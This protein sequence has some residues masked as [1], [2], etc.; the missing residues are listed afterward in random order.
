MSHLLACQ[1]FT[2]LE[3]QHIICQTQRLLSCPPAY[4]HIRQTRRP[5]RAKHPIR[6][7]VKSIGKPFGPQC[8]V[9]LTQEDKLISVYVLTLHV[10]L[11]KKK[12]R[13]HLLQ[14]GHFTHDLIQQFRE[15]GEK[16]KM[17]KTLE[18]IVNSQQLNHKF[19]Y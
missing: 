11:D 17:P 15:T 9:N 6:H 16:K 13:L 18:N 19:N 1:A 14:L 12:H 7:N 2:A 4:L 5:S 10:Y 8:N 3:N